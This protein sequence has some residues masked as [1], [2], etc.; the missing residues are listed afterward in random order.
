M[1]IC[2]S[3]CLQKQTTSSLTM[4]LWVKLIYAHF[5]RVDREMVQQLRVPATLAVNLG[6]V[7]II[8]PC[9]TQAPGD[10]ISSPGI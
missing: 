7:P 2:V 8:Q 9:V 5:K 3:C 6:S 10:A 1:G 4:L